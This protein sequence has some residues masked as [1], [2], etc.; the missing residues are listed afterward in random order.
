MSQLFYNKN[1]KLFFRNQ[2]WTKISPQLNKAIRKKLLMDYHNHY[3]IFFLSQLLL[4]S[5]H[6]HTE[7]GTAE[8]KQRQRLRPQN[9]YADSF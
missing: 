1:T 7:D 3:D 5:H 4:K 9:L 2:Y 6:T 8:E